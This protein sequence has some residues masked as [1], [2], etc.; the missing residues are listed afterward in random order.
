MTRT[1]TAHAVMSACPRTVPCRSGGAL[2]RPVTD[3]PASVW[4]AFFWPGS[5]ETGAW[6]VSRRS[7]GRPCRAGLAGASR[8]RCTRPP[9][10]VEP[11]CLY[12]LQRLAAQHTGWS[13]DPGR[14]VLCLL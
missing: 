8:P 1:G 9:G 6:P 4:P 3:G 12:R 13:F 2:V 11:P 7:I 10:R 14:D 5:H